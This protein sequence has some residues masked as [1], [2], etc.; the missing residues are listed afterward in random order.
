[1]KHSY[2]LKL[3][4]IAAMA[5]TFTAAFPFESAAGDFTLPVYDPVE[6]SY[7]SAPWI[8]ATGYFHETAQKILDEHGT[9][10]D[11]ITRVRT[12]AP[13]IKIEGMKEEFFIMNIVENKAEKRAAIL[14][15]IGKHCYLYLEEGREFPESVLRNIVDRFDN[16]IYRISTETFGSE[17]KPGIDNDERVTI[18][19]ADIKDGWKPGKGFV[20]GYFSPLDCYPSKVVQ[21]SNEREMI[22][23]DCHP[24]NPEDPFYPGVIAHEFQH[25]IHFANDPREDKWL[26]EGCSQLAFYACGY[27][28]PSQI[29]SYAADPGDD[30]TVWQNSMEDYGAVYLLHYYIYR[31]YAGSTPEEKMRFYRSLVASPLKD[32]ESIDAVLKEFNVNKTFEDIYKD[33]LVANL[34]NRP[35]AGD[36]RYGYDESLTMRVH[37]T[38]NI[39][40]LPAKIE[41]AESLNHG[42]ANILFTPFAEHLPETPTLI[43][44]FAVYSQKP[45]VMVWGING[46]QTPSEKYVPQGSDATGGFVE[47]K[48][49]GPDK[50]GF[51]FA[52]IGPFA[53]A[54]AVDTFNYKLRYEDGTVSN[55]KT[56]NIIGPSGRS[57]AVKSRMAEK[58]ILV[59]NFR[60]SKPSE[61]NKNKLFRLL[62]IIE[63]PDG[64]I[65]VGEVPLKN[66]QA[67]IAVPSYGI[68]AAKVYFIAYQLN[69]KKL[70]FNLEADVVSSMKEAGKAFVMSQNQ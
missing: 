13:E 15:K 48:M 12:A 40:A 69:D 49:S 9:P 35:D 67:K 7:K 65:T 14:K 37:T 28:H 2:L 60:G 64:K 34:I 36:G 46:W 68:S 30:A 33:W 17:P 38:H 63:D 23:L 43:E 41:K 31:K 4:C 24:A 56:I 58:N 45:A 8:D 53:G 32:I 22:Y 27:D 47:T 19:M 51:Y 57:G 26:N 59:V 16:V 6:A 1:M 18:L 62:E 39:T 10:Q 50:K 70:S 44:K 55:E 61:A 66:N 11:N 20:G 25:M 42:A 29:L 21:Y 54:A 3:F 5:T 52:E